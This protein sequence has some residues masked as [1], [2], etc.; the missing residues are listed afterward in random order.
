MGRYARVAGILAIAMS[1]APVPASAAARDRAAPKSHVIEGTI[2]YANRLGTDIVMMD[3]TELVV[4]T[5]VNVVHSELEAR[6]RIKAY[7]EERT[8]RK[9]VTQVEV[10]ER[11][12][13]A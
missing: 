12:P 10:Y 5:T 11:H 6:R 3:G 1:L 9:V 4:P 7:Y 2:H 8:G 13:G